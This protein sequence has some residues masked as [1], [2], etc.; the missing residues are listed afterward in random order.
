MDKEHTDIPNSCYR[1]R[2]AEL[3]DLCDNEYYL[4]A[5]GPSLTSQD[6]AERGRDRIKEC[7]KEFEILKDQTTCEACHAE[8]NRQLVVQQQSIREI[9]SAWSSK[10]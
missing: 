8:I 5:G 4:S 2:L 7:I 10:K 9:D 3:I 6:R 1:V